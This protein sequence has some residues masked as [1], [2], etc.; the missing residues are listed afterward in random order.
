MQQI[1]YD[2]RPG[3]FADAMKSTQAARM[4]FWL[5]LGLALIYQLVAFSLVEFGGVLDNG[6]AAP[7]AV[8]EALPVAKPAGEPKTPPTPPVAKAPEKKA[9]PTPPPA[10]TPEKKAAPSA[11]APAAKPEAAAKPAANPAAPAEAQ[12]RKTPPTKAEKWHDVLRWSLPAAK[13][14]AMVCGMLLAL[15]LLFAVGLSLIG[16][17]GGM[18]GMISG[19]FWSLILFVM[20]VPWQQVL[21]KSELACGALYNL[22][23]LLAARQTWAPDPHWRPQTLYYGRFVVYPGVALLI[24]LIVHVKFTRGVM[25]MTFPHAL[26][27]G[28]IPV[29]QPAPQPAAPPAAKE[30]KPA[31]P[32]ALKSLD[33]KTQGGTGRATPPADRPMG[34]LTER[35]FKAQAESETDEAKD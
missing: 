33:D 14:L 6:G 34:A 9:P 3:E 20:V 32:L 25:R 23:D 28:I 22:G 8:E 4:I 29:P 7:A 19:F 35:L 27:A 24:W 30:D 26:P 17:L 15:T 1:Q 13:F 12:A 18:A 31:K 16:K 2:V 11:P 5:L 21:V 10:K